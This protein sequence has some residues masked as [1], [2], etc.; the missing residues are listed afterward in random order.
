MPEV[1]RFLGII[2]RMFTET[3]A[4]HHVPHLHAFR[5]IRQR[6]GLILASFWQ[7]SCHADNN[8]WWKRGLNYIR[9]NC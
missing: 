5:T 7:A 6:I 9:K 1:S 4:Q 2:I 8:A 3:G